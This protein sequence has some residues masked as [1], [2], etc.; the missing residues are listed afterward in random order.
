MKLRQTLIGMGLV[1]S[2]MIGGGI[3]ASLVSTANAATNPTSTST[4]TV[5]A[6]AATDGTAAPQGKWHSNT[7]ATHEASESPARAAAEAAA[8]ASGVAPAPTTGG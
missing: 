2:T 4:T 5:P 8:D 1:A 7:D 6:P 3:G